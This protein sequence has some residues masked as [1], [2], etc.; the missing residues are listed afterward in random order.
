MPPATAVIR[1]L[2]LQSQFLSRRRDWT[3]APDEW[4][5]RNAPLGQSKVSH[6]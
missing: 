5:I 1:L 2:T 4:P 3:S 6:V